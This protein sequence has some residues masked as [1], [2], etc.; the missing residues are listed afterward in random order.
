[1]NPHPQYRPA[2]PRSRHINNQVGETYSILAVITRDAGLFARCTTHDIT[3]GRGDYSKALV[4]HSQGDAPAVGAVCKRKRI[5][6][7][8]IALIWSDAS[9]RVTGGGFTTAAVPPDWR[10]PVVAEF[11][12][13]K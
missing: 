1:M 4:I 5:G 3:I 7:N 10:Q 8:G 11:G 12:E 9:G 13:V 2:V 6:G